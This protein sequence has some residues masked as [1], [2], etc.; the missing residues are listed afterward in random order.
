M[1]LQV[2][3]R[4]LLVVNSYEHAVELFEKR[5]AKYSSCAHSIMLNDL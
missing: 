4:G 3:G 5:S 1:W 2:F